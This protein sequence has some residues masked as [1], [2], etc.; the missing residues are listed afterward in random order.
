MSVTAQLGITAAFEY[1]HER[2]PLNA[3]EWLTTPHAQIDTLEAMPERCTMAREGEYLN[4]E[5]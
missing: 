1:I 3:E 4:E 5:L 2:S